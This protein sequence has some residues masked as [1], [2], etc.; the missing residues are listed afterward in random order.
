MS[1]ETETTEVAPP[2]TEIV[3]EQAVAPD[4]DAAFLA[5]F[6]GDE[7]AEEKPADPE[8]PPTM[9]GFTEDQFKELFAKAQEVD[10]L[11]EREAKVFGTLGSLKQTLDNLRQQQPQATAKVTKESLK[12][13]SAEFPEMAEMLAD[14]LSGLS[15]QSGSGVDSDVVERVVNERMDRASKEYETKLL[16]VMHRDWKQVVQTPEFT[17]WKETLPAEQ[18]DVLENGWDA[19]SIGEGI[20]AFKEWKSK[21]AQSSASN[22]RRLE[23]AVTPRSSARAVTMTDDDAFMEGFNKA[24]GR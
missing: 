16:T 22:K 9:F 10:R 15:V 13:L 14:D 7:V 17:Q 24:R 12:R 4:D 20:S 11:K 23:A 1:I 2:E 3:E 6:N 18:R 5:G 21:A 8:P 19:V